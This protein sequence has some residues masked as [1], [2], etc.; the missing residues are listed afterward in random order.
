MDTEID[1]QREL[2][3][4]FGS[5][6]DVAAGH[7]V[8]AGRRAVRRRRATMAAAGV[9]ASIV[10]GT[11]WALAPGDAP[12]SDRAPV[13]TEPSATASPS[14]PASDPEPA[15][16]L[17]WRKGEPP[18]RALPGGLEIRP[19]AVVHERRD[20]LY[21]G[22]D[23]ESAA[24]D[25]S[26]HGSRWWLVLEWDKGGSSMSSTRPEDGFADSFDAFVRSEV[27][28]GGMTSVPPGDVPGP[29]GGLATWHGG[30]LE[31]AAGV[32]VVRQVEGPVPGDDSLGVVLRSEGRTTWALFTQGGDASTW[33]P[34][35]ESGWLTFDQ[36]LA[37]QVAQQTGGPQ[38]RLVELE[39]DGT[40]RPAVS[41]VEV[42][43]QRARPDLPPYGTTEVPSA[44]ALVSW[45]G[46][47]WFVLVL[48]FDGED[49]VTTF[50]A[51]KADGATTLD[52]FVAFAADRGDE[53]GLR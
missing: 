17:P 7:Y 25:I 11:T 4:S 47:R 14:S 39:D 23:T 30:H 15:A 43:D 32:T 2:D 18:A 9:A 19:G 1:W 21:P 29:A 53:G 10:V 36:W 34:E 38:V 20:A 13:A 51:E 45:Q 6:P 40:V 22:K 16:S 26:Y 44:L 8:T 50:A 5:A 42:L 46:E 28:N 24:L 49:G 12:R 52:D 41:G 31:T 35:A 37:D 3:A 27:A 33:E 48:G